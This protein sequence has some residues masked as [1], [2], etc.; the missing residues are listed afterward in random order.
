MQPPAWPALCFPLSQE[1]VHVLQTHWEDDLD[2]SRIVSLSS[3]LQS[4]VHMPSLHCGH[5]ASYNSGFQ[6]ISK[7]QGWAHIRAW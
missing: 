6:F 4:S 1:R 2:P 3:G 5:D 7:F